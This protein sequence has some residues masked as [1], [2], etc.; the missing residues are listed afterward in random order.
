MSW[1]AVIRGT[2][3]ARTSQGSLWLT[4][5]VEVRRCLP[6]VR[7]SDPGPGEPEKGDRSLEQVRDL[8]GRQDPIR[9]AQQ[10]LLVGGLDP[11]T[12]FA[13]ETPELPSRLS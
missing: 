11:A 4:L 8:A 3:I 5:G 12:C 2:D 6:T 9:I 13:V 1:R 7:G 10:R